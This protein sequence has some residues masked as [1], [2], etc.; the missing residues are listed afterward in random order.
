MNETKQMVLRRRVTGDRRSPSEIREHYDL[1]VRL[2]AELVAAPKEARQVL[3]TKLYDELFSKLPHHPQLTIKGDKGTQDELFRQK[4]RLV[5]RYVDADTTF[6]EIGPGDCSFSIRMAAIVRKVYAVDVSSQIVRLGHSLPPNFELAISDGSSIP[7]PDRSVMVVYSNQLM[8]H[9]H[10]E[11]AEQQ[12]REIRRVLKP[13]GRYICITPSRFSGPHDVSG[14]FDSSARGFH[15]REYSTSELQKLLRDAG[16]HSV[17]TYAG[18]RGYYVRVPGWTSRIVD[19]VV[20]KLPDTLRPI[21][22]NWLPVRAMLGVILV[23]SLPATSRFGV[24]Q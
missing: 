18:G 24:S 2:A 14:Y 15:L 4:Y 1:E 5:S 12:L 17:H 21:I 6:L 19:A 16:F 13:G 3:Y 10:P 22:A 11:D 8:E 23:G 20:E 7:L 9:L